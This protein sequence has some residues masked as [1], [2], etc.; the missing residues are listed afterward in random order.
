MIHTIEFVKLQEI[1][2]DPY[3]P[4]LGRSID[5]EHL[6]QD[7]IFDRMQDWSLEE[8]AISFLESGF[9]IHEAVL[10]IEEEPDNGKNLIVVE[11]NRRIAALKRLK[12]AFSGEENS[13]KWLQII[14]GVPQP[15]QLFNEVPII[16][17]GSRDEISSFLGFRHVT[18]IKQ[19]APP[20]KAQFIAKMINENRLSYRDVMHRIGSKTPTIERMYIAYCILRQ[21]D[22]IEDIYVKEVEDR[23][24]VLF[25]SLRSR[26]VREFLGIDDK[27]N[28]DPQDVYPPISRG[29]ERNLVEFSLWLFG[30]ENTRPVVNDSR[31]IDKFAKVLSSVEGVNYL[32]MIKRPSL[33]KAF[34]VAGGALEEIYELVS[35][36]A[37]SLQEALSTIHFHKE[38]EKLREIS[39]KMLSTAQQVKLTLGIED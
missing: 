28:I 18:G 21:M 35:S 22:S 25:L 37:Y 19:W 14:D 12:R 38:D 5:G 32:R 9:W 3:N 2:L 11:G 31:Q 30:D 39:K 27:F 15:D 24:S 8:L 26:G 34:I 33:E 1:N 13:R 29:N 17:I 4:R 10:C 16:K 6:S 23:F 36:A 7:E 20:E